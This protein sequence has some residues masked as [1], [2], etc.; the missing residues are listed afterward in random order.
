[1]RISLLALVLVLFVPCVASAKDEPS[2]DPA[3][4][5]EA[6]RKALPTP[7]PD[8]RLGFEGDLVLDK[9][10]A[11]EVTYNAGARM[12]AGKSTWHVTETVFIDVGGA[13][14]NYKAAYQLG[15]D[16]SLHS[17]SA[18]CTHRGVKVSVLFAKTKDG[19]SV[20]R[21]VKGGKV[22]GGME[23]TTLKCA[24]NVTYG[25]AAVLLFLRGVAATAD[26]GATYQLAWFPLWDMTTR[27][28]ATGLQ[29]GKTLAADDPS[30]RMQLTLKGQRKAKD[31]EGGAEWLVESARGDESVNLILH[32]KSK[33]LRAVEAAPK[34]MSVRPRGTAGKRVMLNEEKPATSWKQAFMKFGY[35][36]HMARPKL[37]KES[38]HWQ[39]MMEYERDVAKSWPADRDVA[40]FTESWVKEFMAG[41]QHRTRAAT[42]RLLSMTLATGKVTEKTDTTIVFAAH[43]NFGGG[44][45][46]TYHLKKVDKL[47]YIWRIDF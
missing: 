38:F 25:R 43:A 40:D 12:F 47:W 19:F 20:M 29:K 8:K 9:L 6:I 34:K 33:T 5:A 31:V 39:T 28:T 18:E 45:Q 15:A 44:T 11:G 30:R 17:G 13:E 10:W 37:I 2:T 41:S 24:A 21:T 16:L 14:L 26:A 22:A 42:D 36:Y 27:P 35:G 4:A 46:R 32:P 3:A 1:M 23:S 7:T